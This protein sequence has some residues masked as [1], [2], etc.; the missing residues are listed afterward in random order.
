[1]AKRKTA[2][3]ASRTRT[4]GA[5]RAAT[6]GR[7]TGSTARK[8]ATGRPAAARKAPARASA[9]QKS[10]GTTGTAS[11]SGAKKTLARKN[12]AKTGTPATRSAGNG[13]AANRRT[14]PRTE[15]PT[16]RGAR[17]LVARRTATGSA[18]GRGS[19]RSASATT[20]PRRDYGRREPG[21]RLQQI[22]RDRRIVEEDV[23]TPP[24]SLDLDRRPSAAR[25]GRA[26]MEERLQ[27]HTAAGPDLTAGDVDAD[28]EAAYSTGDEA[29][30]G[31]MPTPDQAV[32]AEIGTAIGVEY[33][34]NEELKAVDKIEQRDRHRWEL[35]PASSE[36]YE[37]RARETKKG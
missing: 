2:R 24:S 4:P 16:A 25:T 14:T 18:G 17:T 20:P 6:G 9:A 5:T 10:G 32:V 3:S 13:G 35:D 19:N 29:P 27:E 8:T 36:D 21:D 31:D 1:M 30:G 28:W 34:D 11:R 15:T 37:E 33:A 7:S 22:E 23:P 12:A 26:E